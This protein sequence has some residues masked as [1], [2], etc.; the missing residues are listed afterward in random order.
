MDVQRLDLGPNRWLAAGGLA[1]IH[2]RLWKG[3][4]L[5]ITAAPVRDFTLTRSFFFS[6]PLWLGPAFIGIS[7]LACIDSLDFLFGGDG[8]LPDLLFLG[9]LLLC[10][11]IMALRLFLR[12][13]NASYYFDDRYVGT[14]GAIDFSDEE[15][16]KPEFSAFTNHLE[17]LKA[18]ADDGLRRSRFFSI[19]PWWSGLAFAPMAILPITGLM[20]L[21]FKFLPWPY[22]IGIA[23]G[24][25]LLAYCLSSGPSLLVHAKLRQ[26]QRYLLRGDVENAMAPLKVFL[27]ARPTHR[28]GTRLLTIT[29][30]MRCNLD[31]AEDLVIENSTPGLY[32]PSRMRRIMDYKLWED[33]HGDETH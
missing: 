19:A 26:A 4:L 31:L 6:E 28:H 32:Q 16:G 15:S 29:E 24:V 14:L 22:A 12:R 20:M 10:G 17:S 1:F 3:W 7:I 30:L 11:A 21:A 8:N 23:S 13:G 25:S 27:T 5:R 2:V 18:A 9:L 33:R